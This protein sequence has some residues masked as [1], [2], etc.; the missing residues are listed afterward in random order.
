MEYYKEDM[1]R[2]A[3]FYAVD[4]DSLYVIYN[5]A[6]GEMVQK[7]VVKENGR[8]SLLPFESVDLESGGRK[9]A[10]RGRGDD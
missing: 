2:D 3:Y 4:A 10:V 7:Y 8:S 1:R 5:Q 6:S 9:W